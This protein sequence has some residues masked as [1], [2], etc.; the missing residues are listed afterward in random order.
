MPD[1]GEGEVVTCPVCKTHNRDDSIGAQGMVL[2]AAKALWDGDDPIII[3]AAETS[4]PYC[5]H[6]AVT[7][8]VQAIA[9]FGEMTGSTVDELLDDMRGQLDQAISER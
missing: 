9:Q 1:S 2:T 8:Y 4:D 5:F 6:M 3:A 7:M